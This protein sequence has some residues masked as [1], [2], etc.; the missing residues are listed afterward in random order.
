MAPL[1]RVAQAAYRASRAVVHFLGLAP[2]SISANLPSGNAEPRCGKLIHSRSLR[3]KALATAHRQFAPCQLPISTAVANVPN[4]RRFHTVIAHHHG[5]LQKS[6]SPPSVVFREQ[7]ALRASR[8]SSSTR[9]CRHQKL[10]SILPDDPARC[11]PSTAPGRTRDRIAILH[12]AFRLAGIR[13]SRR[14][15]ANQFVQSD[16]VLAHLLHDFN[17]R[18]PRFFFSRFGQLLFKCVVLCQQF[19]DVRTCICH[20][21]RKFDRLGVL[22]DESHSSSPISTWRRRSILTGK[23]PRLTVDAR[24]REVC[25]ATPSPL[26]MPAVDTAAEHTEFFEASPPS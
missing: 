21:Y 1:A 6:P 9:P 4:G 25:F 19:G 3:G 15:A 13:N 10:V 11:S 7:T 26:T 17:Q 14:L 18:K 12:E 20:R 23:V 24:T 2:G 5:D 22:R 8:W 16:L